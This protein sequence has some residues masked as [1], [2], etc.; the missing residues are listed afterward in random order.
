MKR[1][2]GLHIDSTNLGSIYQLTIGYNWDKY[3]CTTVGSD[4][5]AE[6]RR[7]RRP[8]SKIDGV[9]LPERITISFFG[10]FMPKPTKSIT[11]IRKK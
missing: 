9:R 3:M 6:F 10:N 8:K 2:A 5:L 11:P 1:I 4:G 7:V